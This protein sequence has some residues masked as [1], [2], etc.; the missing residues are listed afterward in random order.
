[1]TPLTALG[2]T[3]VYLSLFK[4]LSFMICLFRAW[5]SRDVLSCYRIKSIH[6]VLY[7]KCL[8]HFN[9][10]MESSCCECSPYFRPKNGDFNIF[11]NI[12][13]LDYLYWNVRNLL[14]LDV[15]GIKMAG[16]GIKRKKDF[17]IFLFIHL[18]ISPI[19]VWWSSIFFHL[20][21]NRHFP[22]TWR[23]ITNCVKI[24]LLEFYFWKCIEQ[25]KMQTFLGK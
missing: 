7:S 17:L 1:M 5:L 25:G 15:W 10:L 14:P 19:C 23:N 9:S 11:H 24:F 4:L 8:V 20:S 2:F 3:Y 13:G 21:Q 12:F 22:L 16:T 6:A 18:I